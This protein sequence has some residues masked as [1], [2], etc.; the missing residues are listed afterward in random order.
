MKIGEVVGGRW[1]ITREIGSGGMGI[2]FAADDVE[3]G[4]P[5]AVKVLRDDVRD[6]EGTVDR[7]LREVRLAAHLRSKHAVRILGSGT[8][9]DAPFMVMELLNGTCLSRLSKLRARVQEEE[10]VQWITDAC[11]A[12]GEA[13]ESGIVHRDL[14]LGNLFLSLP[15]AGEPVV[16][17][18]DFGLAKNLL[19][20]EPSL[21]SPDDGFGTPQFMPPEQYVDVREVDARSDVWSLAVCLYRLVTGVYPVKGKTLAQLCIE[22]NR[23]DFVA[24]PASAHVATIS[25]H[26]DRVLACALSKAKYDR[27]PDAVHF[28]AALRA[29][30]TE[31]VR[32]PPRRDFAPSSCTRIGT[33]LPPPPRPPR[34][35]SATRPTTRPMTRPASAPQRRPSAM[36]FR[37]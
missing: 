26:L 5:V 8:T 20:D 34:P 3:G 33:P 23:T 4:G 2:V 17:V 36:L 29:I 1:R 15:E 31:I 14:K 19:S 21:T 32:R 27:Y 35:P 9:N 7:F 28:G 24:T 16:K 11:D 22:L 12:V 30:G 18:L 37:T 6:L 10:A 25:P 13:H